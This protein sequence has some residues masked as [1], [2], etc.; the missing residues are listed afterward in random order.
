LGGR[1]ATSSSVGPI[2]MLDPSADSTVPGAMPGPRAKKG[3]WMSDSYC[4]VR[5]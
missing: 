2:S 4:L 5:V 3:M 1:P